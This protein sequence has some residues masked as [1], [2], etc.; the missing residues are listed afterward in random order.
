MTR[1]C[2]PPSTRWC[3]HRC[4]NEG[5]YSGHRYCINTTRS[6]FATAQSSCNL[7][8]GHLVAYQD[9][10]EQRDV[11]MWFQDQGFLLPNFHKF[12]WMGLLTG[13]HARAAGPAVCVEQ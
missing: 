9:M 5:T 11:E 10:H 12:Y 1:P 7:I 6:S 8:G 13:V 4:Y 2:R 3:H